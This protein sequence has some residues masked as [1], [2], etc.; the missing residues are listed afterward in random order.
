MAMIIRLKWEIDEME[1]KFIV[2]GTQVYG[3]AGKDSDLD[4][5]MRSDYASGLEAELIKL[6]IEIEYSEE[7]MNLNYPGFYFSLGKIN[8]N[9]IV[10]DTNKEMEDWERATTKMLDHLPI[11]DR[12]KRVEIF[13]KYRDEK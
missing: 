5:V 1:R 11:K 8:F 7:Q 4:I 3:P 12:E 6:G 13:Q 9:I 10:V 2:T